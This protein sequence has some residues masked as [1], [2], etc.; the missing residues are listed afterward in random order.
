MF[1]IPK[2]VIAFCASIALAVSPMASGLVFAQGF[3]V[4]NTGLTEAASKAGYNTTQ[5]CVNSEGGCIP[6]I[7]G[8]VIS[9]LL[10][11]FGALFLVLIMYGGVQ[12]M[13]A[14]GDA[15]KVKAATQTLRNAILGM[16][17]VTASYA[18]ATYVITSVAG[19]VE[20]SGPAS[21]TP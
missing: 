14:G 18:I 11:V 19:A 1:R 17:V 4:Q 9:S 20:G 8:Q 3:G 7:I 13:F 21:Q 2:T 15:G 12:Y 6:Q 5:A 10:G 16:L